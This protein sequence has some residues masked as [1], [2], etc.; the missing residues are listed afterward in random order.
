MPAG[1]NSPRKFLEDLEE[2]PPPPGQGRSLANLDL[3]T[4]R[5]HDHARLGADIRVPPDSL[6]TLDALQQEGVLGTVGQH[7]VG[8]DRCLQIR[9]QHLPDR[10]QV[11]GA[12]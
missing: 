4:V 11:P 6:A 1:L 12:R 3:V 7:Q 9:G 5:G 10:H 8:G 2:V